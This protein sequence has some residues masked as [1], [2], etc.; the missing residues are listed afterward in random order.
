[1]KFSE[2]L[3]SLLHSHDNDKRAFIVSLHLVNEIPFRCEIIEVS[4]DNVLIRTADRVEYNVN[5]SN[6]VRWKDVTGKEGF[7]FGQAQEH[8]KEVQAT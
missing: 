3:S 4:D 2:K 5:L 1:M 8:S 7:G 6:I